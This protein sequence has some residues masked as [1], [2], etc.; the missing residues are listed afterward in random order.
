MSF[1]K[2]INVGVTIISGGAHE[3]HHSVAPE[4][5]R[6]KWIPIVL[7]IKPCPLIFLTGSCSG[8]T[9]LMFPVPISP[10]FSP[11]SNSTPNPTFDP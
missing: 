10:K 7:W 9:L 1:E 5:K 8:L 11:S 2:E 4:F 6:I 3:P